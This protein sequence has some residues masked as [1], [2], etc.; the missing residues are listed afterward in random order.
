MNYTTRA[1]LQKE[2]SRESNKVLEC[3]KN[4]AAMPIT[5]VVAKV[6]LAY[7]IH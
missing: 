5:P 2:V 6:G 4:L 1:S 3:I 7:L